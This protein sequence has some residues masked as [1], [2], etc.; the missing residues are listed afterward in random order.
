MNVQSIVMCPD[1]GVCP[2][3]PSTSSPGKTDFAKAKKE[4]LLALFL[5]C[6][7]SHKDRLPPVSFSQHTS[8]KTE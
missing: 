2:L 5:V 1:L 8:G 4:T 3:F 6:F 7:Y